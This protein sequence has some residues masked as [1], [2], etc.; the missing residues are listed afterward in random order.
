[1][2]LVQRLGHTVADLD[3]YVDGVKAMRAN[4]TYH[5]YVYWHAQV[6]N[7]HD[8]T[9]PNHATA[10]G[11]NQAHRGPAFLPWHRE[12]IWRFEKDLQEAL[13]DFDF[14]LPYWNWALDK[15][16][17]QLE[18]SR[19]WTELGQRTGQ[20]F[21]RGDLWTRMTALPGVT[22]FPPLFYGYVPVDTHVPASRQFDGHSETWQ[23][24]VAHIADIDDV[25]LLVNRTSLVYDQDQWNYGA[26]GF[27]GRTEREFHDDVHLL[28]G[29]DFGDMAVRTL[30]CNDPLFFMHHAMVDR[31]WARWQDATVRARGGTTHSGTWL[32]ADYHPNMSEAAGIQAGHR[33]AEPMGP[34]RSATEM[35]WWRLPREDVTPRDVLDIRSPR[36]NYIYDDQE[37]GGCLPVVAQ[38]FQELQVRKRNRSATRGT[39]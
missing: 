26:N 27:R 1:M 25:E 9:D 20:I 13:G 31:L 21:L 37:R 12:F 35:G 24:H 4:R 38:V 5:K 8:H 22:P 7:D 30:G 32:A 34:W 10:L 18:T 28:V 2:A 3:R 11:R 39:P 16:E 19:V 14:G 15:T 6:M 36:L 23:G 33:S 17:G 29:G